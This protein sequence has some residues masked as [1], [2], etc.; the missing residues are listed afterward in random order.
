[1]GGG[2]EIN[3]GEA[4]IGEWF[5]ALNRSFQNWKIYISS[6]LS[7][8]EYGNQEVIDEISTNPNAVINDYLHLSVSMR[9]FRAENVSLFVKQ[10]LDLDQENARKTLAEVRNKYPIILTRN[11]ALQRNG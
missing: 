10:L 2:Q 9:S 8:S 1:M 7:D 11:L 6:R 3:T 4:G 5:Y